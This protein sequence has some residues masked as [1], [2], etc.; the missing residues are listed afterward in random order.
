M[1]LHEYIK[2]NG[3]KELA[4]KT[5]MNPLYLRQIGWGRANP[6]FVLAKKIVEA[7]KGQ[8]TFDDLAMKINQKF[9]NFQGGA[10]K[11]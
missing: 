7:T 11:D 5:G 10:K 9:M 8:V 6:S 3:I 1:E 2:T 4:A